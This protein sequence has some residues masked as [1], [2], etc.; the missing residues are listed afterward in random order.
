[1][2]VKFDRPVPSSQHVNA[3]NE[4]VARCL[5]LGVVT[6][7]D[8]IRHQI[9][10]QPLES[11]ESPIEDVFAYDLYKYVHRHG[12][13][14]QRTVETRHGRL[15][16]DFYV[17][18]DSHRVVFEC[19]GRKWHDP[20]RDE[21]RDALVLGYDLAD[22]VYR[23]PGKSIWWSNEFCLYAAS[24][25]DPKVFTSRGRDSLRGLTCPVQGIPESQ[26]V[27]DIKIVVP[28][29]TELGG[30]EGKTVQ[31]TRRCRRASKCKQKPRWVEFYEF[32]ATRNG[33][34]DSIID[35]WCHE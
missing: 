33:R 31:L 35:E 4:L 17:E 12:L 27:E 5:G 16:F 11:P 8:A 32:A 13:E 14:S 25:L 20:F 24:V 18:A 19:D 15:R 23:M 28:D 3:H 26:S 2:R 29:E 6:K 21:W 10:A 7:A 22:T 34:L 1:M 30:R 9:L